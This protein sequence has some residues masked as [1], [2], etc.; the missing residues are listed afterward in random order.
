MLRHPIGHYN[1][2]ARIQ[3]PL[4]GEPNAYQEAPQQWETIA[5]RWARVEPLAG[6]ELVNAQQLLLAV[7]HRLNFRWVDGMTSRCR[8]VVGDREFNLG[9]VV[10]LND[11]RE[12]A[13]CLGQ[14]K[15]A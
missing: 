11:L 3:R 2:I 13:E 9:S 8:V 4:E 15:I 12:E 1:R 14:E 6:R 10:D 7:S 5:T